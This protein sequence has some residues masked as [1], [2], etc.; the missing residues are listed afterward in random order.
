MTKEFLEALNSQGLPGWVIILIGGATIVAAVLAFVQS[1]IV[2]FVNAWASKRVAVYTARREDR[3]RLRDAIDTTLEPLQAIVG[4]AARLR[5]NPRG[6]ATFHARWNTVSDAVI[7]KFDTLK[8][9]DKLLR[10]IDLLE[11]CLQDLNHAIGQLPAAP[12]SDVALERLSKAADDMTRSL[13]ILY[14]AGD[15]FTFGLWLD[16]LEAKWRYRSF[17]RERKRRTFTARK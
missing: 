6:T 14:T 3:Q 8:I 10:P 5:F 16:R 9:P 12:P 15:A 17:V 2:A 11:D 7:A 13:G 4:E 1:L